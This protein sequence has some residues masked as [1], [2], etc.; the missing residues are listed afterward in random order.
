[1]PGQGISVTVGAVRATE[2]KVQIGTWLN[3]Q[4]ANRVLEGILEARLRTE[5]DLSAPEYEVLFR[6]QHASGHLLLMSEI[7]AQLLNSP[8][9]ATRIADRLE[10]G[11]LIA[12]R[13]PRDNRRVVQVTLTERGRQALEKADRVFR[14]AL[15][16]SFAAHLSESD[17]NELRRLMRKLLEGNGAWTEAR[18]SPG[19]EPQRAS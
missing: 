4:Q 13:T 6:L 16:E 2:E 3:L 12:R 14:G 18:C 11:G 10:A 8:S 15:R 7:A 9:G 1:M 19:L 5:T 17:V